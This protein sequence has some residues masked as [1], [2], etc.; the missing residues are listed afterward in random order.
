MALKI[1][2]RR[3][4]RKN[5]PTYRVVVAESSMPRDGRIVESL[6]HYNPRTEPVTLKI[7]RARAL[8]WIDM[9]AVPTETAK[10]L[11][12]RAGIFGPEPSV[13]A[14]AVGAMVE[15]TKKVAKRATGAARAVA[16]RATATAKAVA[17]EVRETAAEVLVEVRETAADV[18]EEVRETAGEVVDGVR[19]RVGRGADPDAEV[20]AEGEEPAQQ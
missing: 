3:M 18:V 17:E 20:P 16:T 1:R 15:G 19:D 13:V 8:H 2:L 10:A 5:A 9:G 7:D 6:G 12:K 11:L 14:E 4:G